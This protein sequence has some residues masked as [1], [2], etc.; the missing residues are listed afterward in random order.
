VCGG[1]VVGA[2][3]VILAVGGV[4]VGIGVGVVV[5]GVVLWYNV[6]VFLNMDGFKWVG[7]LWS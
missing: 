3:V 2:C 1:G 6:M 4:A 7:G 5:G